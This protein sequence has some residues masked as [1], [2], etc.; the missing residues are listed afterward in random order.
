M[1]NK[2]ISIRINIYFVYVSRGMD[3]TVEFGPKK[4]KSL[5]TAAVDCPNNIFDIFFWLTDWFY[6]YL[7]LGI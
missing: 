4:S 5:E 1:F 2:I 7:L 3:I 6:S